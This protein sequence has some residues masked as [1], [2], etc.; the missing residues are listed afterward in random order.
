MGG[1]GLK[2]GFIGKGYGPC[3]EDGG[4]EKT[5]QYGESIG[6]YQECLDPRYSNTTA[7]DRMQMR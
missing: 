4:R 7:S 1:V 6:E 3:R 2:R 5:G